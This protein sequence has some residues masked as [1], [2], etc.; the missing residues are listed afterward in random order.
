MTS[1]EVVSP[2]TKAVSQ[3]TNPVVLLSPQ[4]CVA[5]ASSL[6]VSASWP[7]LALFRTKHVLVNQKGLVCAFY[8]RFM[9]VPVIVGLCEVGSKHGILCGQS[10]YV[11]HQLSFFPY[12]RHPI[13]GTMFC[14][15]TFTIGNSRHHPST[16]FCRFI[17]F[18]ERHSFIRVGQGWL[19]QLQSARVSS[20]QSRRRNHRARK[21]RIPSKVS[22]RSM[23]HEVLKELGPKTLNRIYG[24]SSHSSH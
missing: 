4:I 19:K 20:R 17:S 9:C 18:A 12:Y 24:Q 5:G 23:T 1:T 16:V 15:R 7:R 6:A 14:D 21:P 2:T 3:P 8:V 22:V 10:F 13:N 11:R